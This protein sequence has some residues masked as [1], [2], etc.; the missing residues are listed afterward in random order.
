MLTTTMAGKNRNS[1]C[2]KTHLKCLTPTP[3]SLQDV[4]SSQST[5]PEKQQNH[6]NPETGNGSSPPWQGNS[7]IWEMWLQQLY[8]RHTWNKLNKVP[9]FQP[10]FM[11][12]IPDPGVFHKGFVTLSTASPAW[13]CKCGTEPALQTE[14]QAQPAKLLQLS[15]PLPQQPGLQSCSGTCKHFH[16]CEQQLCSCIPDRDWAEETIPAAVPALWVIPL[17]SA[18]G[19][20]M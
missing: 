5:D 13:R 17:N 10:R 14:M 12:R 20:V 16:Q 7:N 19:S 8:K 9:K 1:Q 18:Q 3:S 4:P 11:K 15:Y 6:R 2:T